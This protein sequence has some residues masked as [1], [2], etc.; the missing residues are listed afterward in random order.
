MPCRVVHLKSRLTTTYADDIEDAIRKHP[1]FARKGYTLLEDYETRLADVDVVLEEDPH[2]A[3][4]AE[5]V[6]RLWF[7]ASAR[8]LRTGS[9]RRIYAHYVDANDA[10]GI[11]RTILELVDD[12]CTTVQSSPP[13]PI[14]PLKIWQP[15]QPDWRSFSLPTREQVDQLAAVHRLSVAVPAS[16]IFSQSI[17]AALHRE[18][19]FR[20]LGI[21]ALEQGSETGNEPDMVLRITGTGDLV[22]GYQ[23]LQPQSSR[24]LLE[25]AVVAFKPDAAAAKI[26]RNVL[27]MFQSAKDLHSKKRPRAL[28]VDS[29]W[30][31]RAFIA[32]APVRFQD[33]LKLQAVRDKILILAPERSELYRIA[34]ADLL[35]AE[36][37]RDALQRFY[38]PDPG[39][40]YNAIEPTL[41]F[42]LGVRG[43]FAAIGLTAAYAVIDGA[44]KMPVR[45]EDYLDI[46][47][48]EGRAI[49]IL[50]LRVPN[51]DAHAIES[52]LATR[53]PG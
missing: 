40:I 10:S 25:G 11:A 51:R 9:Q 44:S 30:S 45:E 3:T 6:E 49:R 34:V 13:P 7:Y 52:A 47:W 23:L 27:L 53:V 24:P 38:L 31:V 46:A 35:A 33:Q 18:P 26:A 20:K 16:G 19:E 37:D 22:W 50:V 48:H 5:G 8:Y 41:L 32:D 15:L 14:P 17:V 29:T 12:V 42:N 2:K 36:L 28:P 43:E 21:E 1:E 39:R 4:A